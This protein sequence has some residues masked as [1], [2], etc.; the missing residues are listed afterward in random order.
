M[1]QIETDYLVV[2]SGAVGMAFVDTM[3]DQTDA[4]IT[5]VDRHGK[6]GGHWNDAYSFVALHQPSAF[7]GVDGLP[8]GEFRKDSTGV[9]AG[10]YELASGPEVSGYFERVMRQRFL[11]TGRVTYQPMSD[12]RGEGRFV[13]LLSGAETKVTVRKKTVDATFF[14]T[15]VPSTHTPKFKISEGVAFAPLNVL[16][17]LWMKPEGLPNH[18]VIVGA[19]KTAMDA[20]V[21]LLG[22]GAAPETI[23]WIMPRDSWL[24]NRTKTQPGLEFF[25]ETIV[26]QAD[27]MEAFAAATGTDDLFMRLEACGV[28]M[29][30]DQSVKPSMFHYA[31]MSKGE[32]AELARVKDVIRLG[33]V[34]EINPSKVVFE[35]GEKSFP[36][37]TLYVDCTASAVPP[38]PS[39]PV[40][41]DGLI[42]PQMIRV[43]Q[44][45]FSAALTAYVEANYE[46]DAQKNA[47]CGPIPLPHQLSDFPA[48]ALGNMMNQ[49]AWGRDKVLSEWMKNCRLDGFGKVIAQISP[50]DE[51]KIAVLKRMRAAAMPAAA[52]LSRLIGVA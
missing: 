8:L 46:T 6:P 24:L 36:P 27:Q 20:I 42:T 40:F 4:H 21:W 25:D 45:A 3:L 9:N 38:R 30:T 33:R 12:Y 10:L 15:T 43:P 11:P 49:F 48:A 39:V 7:Y 16:P 5:I 26:G 47:F 44:P 35:H 32:V 37:G 52:N 18:F 17:N 2:G 1:T 13:S 34:T 23:S 41:Q 51:E 19:G 50:D 28:M 31:T 14:N 29:R 22:A